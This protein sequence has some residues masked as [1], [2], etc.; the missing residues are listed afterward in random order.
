MPYVSQCTLAP[1]AQCPELMNFRA[2]FRGS[3]DAVQE[4]SHVHTHAEEHVSASRTD[5]FAIDSDRVQ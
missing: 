4:A 2:L 3:K 5:M 1:P